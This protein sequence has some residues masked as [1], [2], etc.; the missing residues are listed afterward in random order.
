MKKDKHFR[1]TNLNLAIF[2][3]ANNQQISG[4]N[5]VNREQKEFAFI[6]TNYLEELI[7]LYKFGER[8][9]E[10]LLINVHVYE[11]ARRVLLD[12]LND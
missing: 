12:R 6:E 9:D 5:S 8:D 10:R 3:F 4:I 11:H 7:W 1:T 2:L